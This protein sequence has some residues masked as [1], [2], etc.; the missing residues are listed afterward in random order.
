ML[1]FFDVYKLSY[2]EKVHKELLVWSLL[3]NGRHF[4]DGTHQA[5][6]G[7]GLQV[8]HVAWPILG[9]S[10]GEHAVIYCSLPET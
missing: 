3:E 7:T 9:V 6:S 8:A 10:K 2:I 5:L 4:P 1:G